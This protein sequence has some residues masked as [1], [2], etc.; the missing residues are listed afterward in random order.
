M[1]RNENSYCVKLV[2]NSGK[3]I[4][5]NQIA[6]ICHKYRLRLEFFV[7]LRELGYYKV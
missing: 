1:I 5:N 4:N 7:H 6:E 3:K 2:S